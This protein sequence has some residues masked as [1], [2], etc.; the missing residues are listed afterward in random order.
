DVNKKLNSITVAFNANSSLVEAKTIFSKNKKSWFS[1]GKS[2]DLDYKIDYFIKM[3]KTNAVDLNVDYGAIYLE[4]L[5]GKASINCDYGKIIVGELS[6]DNNNINLDYCTSSSISYLKNGNISVDY[7]K[8]YIDTSDKI[9]ASGD[10]SNL[11]FDKVGTINVSSD[12]GSIT[13]NDAANIIADSD[14]TT[15]HFGT[16][17]RKMI[18]DTDYGAI[19]IKNLAKGFEKIDISAQY[20]D[21]KIGVSP[22]T[23]FHFEINLQ[24]GT[25]KKNNKKVE[26]F[27]SISKNSRK[28]YEG[29][30]GKGKTNSMVKIESQYGGIKMEENN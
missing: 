13:I 20:T 1:W 11:K 22:E 21:V 28:H 10:Y 8:L 7:S 15:M 3:P 14:Y 19:I 18:I 4:D 16:I 26:I 23:S 30:Y 29:K 5:S 25:F 27:K 9:N 17:R 2:D 12:Y 6:A 24:Y